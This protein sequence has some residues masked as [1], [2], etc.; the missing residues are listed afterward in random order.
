M[1]TCSTEAIERLMCATPLYLPWDGPVPPKPNHLPANASRW[2]GLASCWVHRRGVLAAWR[3]QEEATGWQPLYE[4]L[5]GCGWTEQEAP[6]ALALLA[7]LDRLATALAAFNAPEA[8]RAHLWRAL[9]GDDLRRGQRVTGA[10]LVCGAQAEAAQAALVRGAWRPI[11]LRRGRFEPLHV[12][13][14]W[15]PAMEDARLELFGARKGSHAGGDKGIKGAMGRAGQWGVLCIRDLHR[16]PDGAQDALAWALERERFC[17]RSDDRPQPT[18]ALL[19]AAT[20]HVNAPLTPAL[21]DRLTRID[22]GADAPVPA[23]TTPFAGA[24]QPTLD[25]MARGEANAREVI[26]A[27]CRYLYERLGTYDAVATASGLDRR[28]VKKHIDGA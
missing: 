17:A 13:H 24:L 25:A 12:E 28:T 5:V 20:R 7:R 22:L 1:E 21:T 26:V 9:I 23:P 15:P 6:G 3:E 19:I 18:P 27:Y 4:L 14:L 11:D 2:V 16:L 10:L 8:D